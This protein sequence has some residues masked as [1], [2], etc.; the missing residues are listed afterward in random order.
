MRRTWRRISPL[1]GMQCKLE[2]RSFPYVSCLSLNG[3]FGERLHVFIPGSHTPHQ[4]KHAKIMYKIFTSQFLHITPSLPVPIRC[5]IIC[6]HAGLHVLMTYVLI[7]LKDPHV[8]IA[9]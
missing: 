5:S 3:R 8:N 2:E 7:A 6:C 1:P 9:L 4:T